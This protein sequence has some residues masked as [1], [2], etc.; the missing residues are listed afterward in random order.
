MDRQGCDVVICN[1]CNHP[2]CKV[3]KYDDTIFSEIFN[4]DEYPTSL[5]ML[6]PKPRNPFVSKKCPNCNQYIS[7]SF[8]KLDIQE[9]CISCSYIFCWVCMKDA[10]ND[11]HYIQEEHYR[12]RDWHLNL[13]LNG[14]NKI[15]EKDKRI[16]QSIQ[17]KKHK[18]LFNMWTLN[19]FEK[20][21]FLYIGDKDFVCISKNHY[22]NVFIPDSSQNNYLIIKSFFDVLQRIS[23]FLSVMGDVSHIMKKDPEIIIRKRLLN[24]Y[25]YLLLDDFP[26]KR[27]IISNN[28]NEQYYLMSHNLFLIHIEEWCLFNRIQSETKN[29]SYRSKIMN[30]VHNGININGTRFSITD[31]L[32][33]GIY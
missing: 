8:E 2:F 10:S 26:I 24:D 33:K 32:L 6:S 17:T 30:F 15:P 5:K 11:K 18:G 22:A 21:Y 19:G 13:L 29:L 25:E 31:I 20:R 23:M 4:L 16:F 7:R 28:K 27:M 14:D 3:S 1:D 9:K 12:A